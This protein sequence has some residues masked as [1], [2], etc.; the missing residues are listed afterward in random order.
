MRAYISGLHVHGHTAI[1]DALVDAYRIMAAQDA[2]DPGRISSIVLLTDGENNTGRDLASFIA[3]YRSLP[4][5]SPPVY[6]IAFGEAELP[7]LAE[8]ASVTGGI[9][10]D[11]VAQPIGVLSTIFDEI[12]GY[13]LRG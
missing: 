13:Q 8:V 2:A 1:Y 10:F 11:A 4:P 3:Y 9:A 6:T 5:G 12:R 7:P